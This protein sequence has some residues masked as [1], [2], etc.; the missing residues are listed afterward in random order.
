[1]GVGRQSGPTAIVVGAGPVGLALACFL[2][3]RDWNVTVIEAVQGIDCTSQASTVQPST[4]D[5]LATIG[6][7]VVDSVVAAGERV[8]EIGYTYDVSSP[9]FAVLPLSR[10]SSVT[11]RPFRLHCEQWKIRA[12]LLD[13]L[14]KQE[15]AELRF[16]DPCTALRRHDD[17]VESVTRSGAVAR[18]DLVVGCDGAH[19]RMRR[20][21]GERLDGDEYRYGLLWGTTSEHLEDMYPL[22]ASVTYVAASDDCP[23]MSLLKHKDHWRIVFRYPIADLAGFGKRSLRRLWSSLAEEQFGK[24]LKPLDVRSVRLANLVV[25]Q[26]ARG[27]SILI[28]DAAHV[29]GTHGGLGMNTG[30]HEAYG[31]AA[32]CGTWHDSGESRDL[33]EVLE[34]Y[35]RKRHDLFVG[36]VI[37]RVLTSGAPTSV[38]TREERERWARRLV[39]VAE[40]G[41]E[42]RALLSRM[43]LLDISP[44]SKNTHAI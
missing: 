15:T 19:S 30:I 36:T 31:L 12:V 1:V 16:G 32:E 6:P 41:E 24:A 8:D 18:G 3:R 42:S 37:P 38:A 40:D 17:G 22:T 35:G 39:D 10:L 9:A 27:R 28:G 26:Y 20:V 14:F 23:D 5:L 2:C 34:A 4:L 25:E 11:E 13:W 7:Q 43:T 33:A 44:L 21:L 29:C